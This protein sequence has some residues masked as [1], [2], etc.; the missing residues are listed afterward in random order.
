MDGMTS[1]NMMPVQWRIQGALGHNHCPHLAKNHHRENSK[2]W[3]GPLCVST[4]VQQ[5]FSSFYEILNTP[6]CQ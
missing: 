2:T 3:L 6:L 5:K 1:Q 4:G